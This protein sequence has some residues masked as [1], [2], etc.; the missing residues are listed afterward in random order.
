MAAGTVAFEAGVFAGAGACAGN[1]GARVAAI[2]G[3]RFAAA[4]GA[5][6]A[7]AGGFLALL[8]GALFACAAGG[9]GVGATADGAGS[10]L[11]TSTLPGKGPGPTGGGTVPAGAFL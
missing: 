2:G 1:G 4:A 6:A 9:A 3:A 7:T 5:G 8:A 11:S 10:I